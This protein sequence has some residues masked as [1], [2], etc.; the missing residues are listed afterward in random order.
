MRGQGKFFSFKSPAPAPVSAEQQEE[1][2]HITSSSWWKEIVC[3][4]QSRSIKTEKYINSYQT[5]L[6]AKSEEIH[7]FWPMILKGNTQTM[8]YIKIKHAEESR[9]CCTI[10][11]N[12]IDKSMLIIVQRVTFLATRAK[13]CFSP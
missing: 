9:N 11:S 3:N 12:S 7:H 5:L 1:K 8:L 6:K 2:C 10:H 4:L 13:K